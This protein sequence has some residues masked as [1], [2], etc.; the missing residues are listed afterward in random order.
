MTFAVRTGAPFYRQQHPA[1]LMVILATLIV[2]GCPLQ[3]IVAAY[4]LDERT[5]MNRQER[6]CR[7]CQRVL[8]DG[9][10][11]QAI[12]RSERYSDGNGSSVQV[13]QG[14]ELRAVFPGRKNPICGC[15][16]N[17]DH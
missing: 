9:T 14:D 10:W 15:P 16:V 1:K 2:H 6:I 17:R 7:Y 3:A 13:N 11:R 5:M 4:R 12:L 8:E